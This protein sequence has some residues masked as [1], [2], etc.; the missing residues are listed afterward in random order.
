MVELNTSTSSI[1]L[2]QLPLGVTWVLSVV[3]AIVFLVAIFL[4]IKWFRYLFYGIV[5]LGSFSVALCFSKNSVEAAQ[6]GDAVGLWI[7]IGIIIGI[8]I[9]ILTGS[10]IAKFPIVRKMEKK[11]KVKT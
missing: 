5:L 8:P 2:S 3:L 9:C 10:L 6:S 1:A 7:L 4:L 11:I